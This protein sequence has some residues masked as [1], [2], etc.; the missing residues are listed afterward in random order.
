[1]NNR[2]WLAM[3]T[4]DD[5]LPNDETRDVRCGERKRERVRKLRTAVRKTAK[6]TLFKVTHY[7]IVVY[8]K[9]VETPRPPCSLPAV[10]VAISSV[11]A[12]A[13]HERHIPL[14]PW[15][16]SA[17]LLVRPASVHTHPC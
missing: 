10:C 5:M 3:Y 6:D 11:G 17:P 4:A 16:S 8:V 2:A 1:M 12:G 13:D 15:S 14:T 7:S 9:S